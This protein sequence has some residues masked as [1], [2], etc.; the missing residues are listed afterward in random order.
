MEQF[1]IMEDLRVYLKTLEKWFAR[2][3]VKGE[4]PTL[5][6][7]PNSSNKDVINGIQRDD[8][9]FS[10]CGN[11][12]HPSDEHG[13]SFS[14]HWQHLK[15]IHRMKSKR[16]PGVPVSV[17]WVLEASDIPSGL[18]FIADPRDR[19]KQHYLL[20]ATERMHVEKLREKLEWIADRM[21][22]IRDAQ[23]GL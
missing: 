19:K 17:Y 14:A 5:Y 6:L 20:C 2:P 1:K 12:I 3:V 4:H 18:A 11:W 9:I 13:L 22:V 7:N 10:S 16:N 15:G 21:S 8:F 23:V